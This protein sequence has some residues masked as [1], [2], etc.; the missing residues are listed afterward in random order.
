MSEDDLNQNL[1]K[2]ASVSASV[3]SLGEVADGRTKKLV[4]PSK[5]FDERARPG[6]YNPLEEEPT[7]NKNNSE[8]SNP[9]EAGKASTDKSMIEFSSPTEVRDYSISEE[10]ILIGD[11][12]VE[13]GNLLVVGGPPG[14]GKSRAVTALAVAGATG[15]DWFGLKVHH[16][17]KTMI[18]QAEN[19]RVRLKNEFADLDCDSLNEW[20]LISPPPPFGFAFLDKRFTTQLK[21]AVSNFKPDVFVIDPWNQLTRDIT[22]RDYMEAF[23]QIR[24]VLPTDANCP[25]IV[26][27]HH[28]R[29]PRF[30]EKA[31]GRS[32]LNILSG[33]YVLTSVPRSVFVMQPASDSPED[34]RIVWTCCKNN[35]GEMG[36]RSVWEIGKGLFEPIEEFEWESFD[37]GGES[38]SVPKVTIDHLKQLFQ[39]GNLSLKKSDAVRKLQAIADIGRTAAYDALNQDKWYGEYLSYRDDGFIELLLPG[40]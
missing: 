25:A 32:L 27:V 34:K 2:D 29:K 30:G 39:N 36:K 24:K 13:R 23:D 38:K 16:R 3:G 26:I 28:T 37:K 4:D 20:I 8:Y 7:G 15:S 14:V 35:N 17:F 31:N 10:T 33:S 22:E 5:Y 9:K 40:E 18:L 12:H 1:E 19:G 11:Y 6:A 21:E